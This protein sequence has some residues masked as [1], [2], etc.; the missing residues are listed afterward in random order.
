MGYRDSE[1]EVCG[2]CRWSRYDRELNDFY[3]QNRDGEN[4]GAGTAYDDSCSD[5]EEKER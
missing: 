3:C 2:T 1:R 4:Y 5:W